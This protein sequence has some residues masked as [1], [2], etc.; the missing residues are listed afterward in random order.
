MRRRRKKPPATEPEATKTRLTPRGEVLLLL[1]EH[2][3]IPELPDGSGWDTDAAEPLLAEIDKGH[4]LVIVDMRGERPEPG[5][6]WGPA[7]V[8]AK[9][10]PASV[11]FYDSTASKMGEKPTGQSADGGTGQPDQQITQ[12]ATTIFPATG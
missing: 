6:F 9:S 12:K 7:V 11:F 5:K 3:I 8:P 10:A 2:G 4:G 1:I